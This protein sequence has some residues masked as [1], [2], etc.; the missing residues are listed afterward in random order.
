MESL[1]GAAYLLK[2][3][4]GVPSGAQAEQKSAVEHKSKSSIDP[5]SQWLG[6]P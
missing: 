6:G 3:N 1:A 2:G 5:A 4:E